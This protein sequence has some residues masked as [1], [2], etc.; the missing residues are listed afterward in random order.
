MIVLTTVV[1]AMSRRVDH[2]QSPPPLWLGLPPTLFWSFFVTTFVADSSD[3]N[4]RQTRLAD[5]YHRCHRSPSVFGLNSGRSRQPLP[6]P[7]APSPSLSWGLMNPIAGRCWGATDRCGT[8]S[9]FHC[10]R[11]ATFGARFL[12]ASAMIRLI[13]AIDTLVIVS[14]S[15]FDPRHHQLHCRSRNSPRPPHQCR[16]W[17]GPIICARSGH[18][19]WPALTQFRSNLGWFDCFLPFMYHFLPFLNGSR[20][21]S[22]YLTVFSVHGT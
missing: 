10:C 20:Y 2:G 9:G 21:N 11:R 8:C 12:P 14:S 6:P 22:R 15:Y 19:V 4:A 18:T 13:V 16:A 7:M 5:D 1:T 3:W 17:L